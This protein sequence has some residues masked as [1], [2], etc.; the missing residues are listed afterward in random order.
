M[1]ELPADLCLLHK[2]PDQ[3]GLVLVAL[4]Q[5]LDGQVAAQVGS[6]P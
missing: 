4:E 6:R 1:L 5:D 2:P 3:L